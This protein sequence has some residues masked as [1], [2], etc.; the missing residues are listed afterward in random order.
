MQY[1]YHPRF[2]V[3]M[4]T[5]EEVPTADKLADRLK[6]IGKE[7]DAMLEIS[8]GRYTEQANKKRVEHKEFEIGDKVWLNQQNIAT[9]RPTLKLDYRR[10]GPFKITAKIG[11]RAYKLQLQKGMKIHNVFHV[12]MLEK[13]TPDALGRE[14]IPLLP[15]IMEEGEEEYEIE[16]IL[17]SRV[18]RNKMEYLI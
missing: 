2:T 4:P 14:P 1:G 16:E 6:E 15:I 17:N 11:K 3:G 12:N 7:A 10:L 13:W 5:V 8:V 9:D 18:Q